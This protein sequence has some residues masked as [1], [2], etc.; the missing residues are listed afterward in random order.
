MFARTDAASPAARIYTYEDLWLLLNCIA[1]TEAPCDA[2]ALPQIQ[3][4]SST[5][6]IFLD[7]Q[8][9]QQQQLQSRLS[10]VTQ[11]RN[12]PSNT[13]SICS[14]PNFPLNLL[15]RREAPKAEARAMMPKLPNSCTRFQV[16]R[17]TFYAVNFFLARL[18]C[19][20][21]ER[22]KRAAAVK[23]QFTPRISS[24]ERVFARIYRVLQKLLGRNNN[25][26]P[27]SSRTL[28]QASS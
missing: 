24:V 12:T 15:L 9:D 11:E 22:A 8:R 23:V 21:D 25:W 18:M 2:D 6:L 19:C 4:T 7:T 20:S 10:R 1:A 13:H 16:S 28:S 17:F 26:R 3:T 5:S 27:A 14:S